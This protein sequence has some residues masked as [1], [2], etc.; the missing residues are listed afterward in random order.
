MQEIFNFIIETASAWGYFG[1]IVL[2][3][4]ESCFIPFP[5]EIVMIPAGYL[6]HKG[7]LNLSL[8]ILSGIFGS[9]LGA[10]INYYL[11]FFWGKGF[12]L[13]YGRFFGITEEKFAKFENF[14]NK[15][16]EFST[17]VCRLLP[18]IRQY[19]SMPAGL[20]KM[21]LVNFIIFT[22]A[23]SGIWVSI[24]VFLGYFLGE[25]EELIKE[26]LHQILLFILLFVFILSIIYIKIKKPF[27]K[28]NR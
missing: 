20:A 5:S 27:I 23:G 10:L 21:K 8:C 4:L 25:N 28:E 12:V 17:F 24:L 26:Y 11:C 13:R 14:F 22:A 1:I 15:H 9:I 6:A 3:T 18:G 7:E 16:G 19:I 2:M